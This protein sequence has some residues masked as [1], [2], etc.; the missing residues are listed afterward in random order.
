VTEILLTIARHPGYVVAMWFLAGFPIVLAMFA[1]NASRQYLWDRSREE[2]ENDLPH[3][4]DLHRAKQQWPVVSVVIPARDEEAVI[5]QTIESVL[6]LHWPGL[7]I[8]VVDDG[9]VDQTAQQVERFAN[10]PAVS[11]ISHETP[12]GKS[13]SLNEGLAQAS[14]PIVLIL[15]AD[16]RPARNV[17]NRMVPHFLHYPDVAAVTGNPR[18]ANVSTLLGKLQAIEFTSTVSTLRRGQS[19]WG[20]V[21]TVSGIMTV[22]K[23]DIVLDQGGFSPI[24][25]TEDIE[26]TWRLHVLGFRCI[27]EPAAQVLMEVPETLSQWWAQRTRWSSGLIRVLQTHGM[28][29]IRRWEWP[30]IPLLLEAILA[31]VWCHVLVVA[32]VFWVMSASAGIPNLGNTLIIGHWGTMTVGIALIQIYWGIR[33]DSH[34]DKT[35]AKLWPVAPMYPLLYWWMGA[36]AVVW[37]SLPTLMTKPRVARWSLARRATA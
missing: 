18:V 9:S 2:T 22:L 37:T 20:R 4:P 31:I 17:L 23:R 26:L 15:D 13:I 11:V 12:R 33:L 25:P 27:Y 14:S 29:I 8:I 19:A 28:G 16:A 6:A 30:I 32:T 10:N 36:F 3:L 7:D 24:Q 21:N 5:A 34:H 1:I 35:I